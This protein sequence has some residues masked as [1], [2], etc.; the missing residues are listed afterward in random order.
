M[1]RGC[2]LDCIDALGEFI[3]LLW[4]LSQTRCKKRQNTLRLVC[5]NLHVLFFWRTLP[6]YT[7]NRVSLLVFILISGWIMFSFPRVKLKNSPCQ[8]CSHRLLFKVILSLSGWHQDFPLI[9]V[10]YYRQTMRAV[11]DSAA[12]FTEQQNG[13]R[14]MVGIFPFC[15]SIVI[16]STVGAGVGGFGSQWAPVQ[17]ECFTD[18]NTQLLLTSPITEALKL[19]KN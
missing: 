13:E 8:H 19:T 15:Q 2:K 16:E 1:L 3:G 17:N 18:T 6:I 10:R 12:G 4:H 11:T 5:A 9:A 14:R 7:L